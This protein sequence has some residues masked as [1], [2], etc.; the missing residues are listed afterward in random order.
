ME[1]YLLHSWRIWNISYVFLQTSHNYL[2]CFEEVDSNLGRVQ[3]VLWWC[4]CPVSGQAGSVPR[5]WLGKDHKACLLPKCLP[6]LYHFFHPAT[7][8][9][10]YSSHCSFMKV[11]FPRLEVLPLL[12]PEG[13]LELSPGQMGTRGDQT[14]HSSLLSLSFFPLSFF[15]FI[16]FR[17]NLW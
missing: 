10:P 4:S 16:S 2:V 5:Q 14:F 12:L 9:F 15:Y 6:T 7:S 1:N 13:D 11:K 17:K 3:R 8:S